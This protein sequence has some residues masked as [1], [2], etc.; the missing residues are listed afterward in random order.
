MTRVVDQVKDAVTPVVDAVS[1][2][3]GNGNGNGSS[4]N[5]GNG[6]GSAAL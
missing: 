5:G 3:G 2:N 1:G 4:S 6:N